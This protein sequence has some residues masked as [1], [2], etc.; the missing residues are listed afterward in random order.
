MKTLRG[1]DDPV[2]SRKIFGA[3]SNKRLQWP[4]LSLDIIILKGF[5]WLWLS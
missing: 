5:Y 2:Q 3:R 1:N 4:P